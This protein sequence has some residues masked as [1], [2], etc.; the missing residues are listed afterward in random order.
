M[1]AG[2]STSGVVSYISGVKC[3][4][5]GEKRGDRAF[6]GPGLMVDDADRDPD[7]PEC[8]PPRL[9]AW[10]GRARS[11]DSDHPQ[12]FSELGLKPDEYQR[13]RNILGRRPTS[14]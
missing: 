14:S 4:K 5:S 8:A 6:F 11:S 10:I 9:R 12:P 1:R 2:A 13:I 7:G 3:Y